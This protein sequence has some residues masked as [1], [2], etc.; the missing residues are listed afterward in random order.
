[1]S[2]RILKDDAGRRIVTAVFCCNGHNLIHADSPVID[3]LNTIHLRG[4]SDSGTEDIYLSPIQGDGRITGGS[5]FTTGELLRIQCPFCRAEFDV[6]APC[7]CRNGAFLALYLNPDCR[8][9]DAVVIC[10]SWG[11]KHSFIKLESSIL[12][13]SP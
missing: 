5:C 8:Y 10:N 6:V 9:K 4:L 12:L 3:G 13:S 11:C 1:M 2:Q 7:F